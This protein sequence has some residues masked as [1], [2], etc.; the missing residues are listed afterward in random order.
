VK[1]GIISSLMLLPCL[2]LLV[3]YHYFSLPKVEQARADNLEK[4]LFKAVF[5]H[6]ANISQS[7]YPENSRQAIY[8]AINEGV[9]HIELDVQISADGVPFI[10]HDESLFK[11]FSID[12][13][14]NE[15]SWEF[16]RGLCTKKEEVEYCDYMPSVEEVLQQAVQENLFIELD[17]KDIET[18]YIDDLVKMIKQN[19]AQ[20]NVFITSFYPWLLYRTRLQSDQIITGLAVKEHATDNPVINKILTSIY[21]P[22]FLGVHVIEPDYKMITSERLEQ[23]KN[24]ELLINTWTVNERSMLQHYLELGLAVTT[25]I[26]LHQ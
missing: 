17:I 21:L 2:V 3:A 14:V 25:D 1:K 13:K 24:N 22:R 6:R 12:A 5:A 18:K 16:I 15:V 20:D 7:I 4:K 23:W 9:S 8:H 19:E 10:F 11:K 26:A